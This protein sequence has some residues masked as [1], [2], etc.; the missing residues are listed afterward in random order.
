MKLLREPLLHFVLL[1]AA[2]FAAHSLLAN[3]SV[4]RPAEIVVTQGKLENLVIG[5]TRTWQ[6]PPTD[7]ELQGLIRDYVREE[8]A[9]RKALAMGLD[10]DD[11]IVRRR[12]RQ[13]LEFISD[14]LVAQTEP[15]DA[16]LQAFLA[17]HPEDFRKEPAFTF[18]QVYLNPQ[19][20]GA[21]L[22]RDAARILAKLQRAGDHADLNSIGDPSLLEQRFKQLPADEVKKMFGEQFVSG[23]ATLKPGQW[24]GP[25]QSGYGAHLV[26]VSERQEARLPA[27]AEVHEEVRRGWLNSMRVESTDRF[28]AALL[29][30]YK[31]KIERPPEKKLAEVR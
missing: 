30:H 17:A 9:Y 15:T 13:K 1:G 18:S 31:V 4:D 3:H 25:V 14:D 19:E 21:N 7:E 20:H 12:L 22:Q 5:F 10:R 27:L 6:R 26:F 11:T 29:Q 8:A 2:I 24:N 28:Y 23:L 16:N